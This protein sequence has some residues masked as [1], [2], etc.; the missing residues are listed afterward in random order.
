MSLGS[1]PIRPALEIREAARRQAKPLS[2]ALLILV[3][4]GIAVLGT[5]VFV[6]IEYRFEQQLH[7]VVKLLLAGIA[8]AITLAVPKF[9][10]LALPVVTPF[11]PWVPPLPI[12]GLNALNLLLVAIFGMYALGRLSERQPLFRPTRLGP[13]LGAVLLLAALSIVRGAAFPTGYGFNAVE[14]GLL[15]FRSATTFAPYFLYLPMI[16]GERDRRRVAW[17]I[18]IGLLVESLVTI[19]FGRNGSGGRAIGSIGQSNEL[20][21]FLSLFTVIAV[22]MIAGTKKLI[23]KLVLAGIVVA[24]GIATM[25]SLSRGALLALGIGL[26]VVALRSSRVLAA[27]VFVLLVTSP[28][29]TPDY[30]KQ[31]IMESSVEVEG[32]DEVAVD[33][34]VESRVNTWQS[35]L[36]VIQDHPIDGVGFSGLAYVLPDVGSQLGLE[37]VKDSSHN[38]FLRMMSEMGLFGLILFIVLL[39]KCWSLGSEG[40]RRATTKF[41]RSLGVALCAGTISLATSCAFG[42]RFFSVVTVSSF[43]TLCAL[44]NDVVLEREAAGT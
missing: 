25:M 3:A 13:V 44:V 17:A 24:G 40:V 31:R 14:A 39:W 18:A 20:G 30:V 9:G 10:L 34:A 41:D 29:W 22:A 8:F 15:L 12:P 4:C 27:L 5:L 16:K 36:R 32:S 21:T 26:L 33:G 35:I 6:A 11:L 43:W 23:G 2:S 7:R 19:A 42:D 1:R 37:D 38:T 28:L